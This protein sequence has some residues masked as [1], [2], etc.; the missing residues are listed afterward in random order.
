MADCIGVLI[1]GVRAQVS[2]Y[3]N[4]SETVF[5]RVYMYDTLMEH[6]PIL[7]PVRRLYCFTRMQSRKKAESTAAQ[8]PNAWDCPST[9]FHMQIVRPLE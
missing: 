1:N 5:G 3:F 6:R 8:L 4:A 2:G 9:G 7:L